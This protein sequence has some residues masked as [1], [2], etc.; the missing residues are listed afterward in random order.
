MKFMLKRI[1]FISVS[2]C[3]LLLPAAAQDADSAFDDA[4][5]NF[6]ASNYLEAAQGFQTAAD[7]ARTDPKA[8][9]RVEI[10]NYNAGVAAM[11]ANDI[12][13]ADKN[14]AR[15]GQAAS[16]LSL[17][18]KAYYNRGNA[19]MELAEALTAMQMPLSP[20]PSSSATADSEAKPMDP[21]K[22]M[23]EAITMYENSILLNP[24]DRDAKINYELAWIKKEQFQQQ[25]EQ[26]PQQSEGDKQ[27]NP[28]DQP[29][30]QPQSQDEQ[31]SDQQEESEAREQ[32]QEN[33]QDGQQDQSPP[34][35]SQE[36]G[37][38]DQ[39]QPRPE[40]ASEEMTP[41]EAAQL[42]DAMKQQEQSQ[43]DQLQYRIGRPV[44][45]EKDW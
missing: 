43:R 42:L 21:G 37:N 3:M 32:Q 45:V 24:N 6:S 38:E 15:A 41:E 13:T 30:E 2:L 5:K 36:D 7:L 28:E 1:V 20:P 23:D 8:Q 17:Q 9:S 26:Q 10:A 27:E 16:D 25:Q 19:L 14:F 35:D 18:A 34:S 22:L 29:G 31:G 12:L 39:Q 44:P 40:P 4:W 11:M 33:Q